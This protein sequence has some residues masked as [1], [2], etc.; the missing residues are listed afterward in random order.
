MT[1]CVELQWEVLLGNKA[2]VR[3]KN[4][5]IFIEKNIRGFKVAVG[6]NVL[7]LGVEV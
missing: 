2:V 7:G 3:N 5:V 1:P 6:N 4:I